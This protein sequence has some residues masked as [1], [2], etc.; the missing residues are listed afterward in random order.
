MTRRRHDYYLLTPGPLTVPR[1]IKEQ[2]LEDRSPNAALHCRMT[3]DIRDYILEICNG[4]GTHVCVPIQGS[5]TYGIEAGL[6][7]LVPMD[8][9]ILIIENG[10]Y[11]QRLREVAE[12]SGFTVV[13]LELPMLPLPTAADIETAL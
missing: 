10:F 9:K 5:A 4:A 13:P 2:M 11:G 6:H 1:E 3:K 7:T 12:G 8:G